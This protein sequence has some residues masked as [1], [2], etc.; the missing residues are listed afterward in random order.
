MMASLMEEGPKPEEEPDN[1]PAEE[2]PDVIKDVDV[3]PAA[4]LD[5]QEHQALMQV[6][7]LKALK[8]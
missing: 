4:V 2:D 3:I 1:I 8:D 5:G 6:Q 7:A